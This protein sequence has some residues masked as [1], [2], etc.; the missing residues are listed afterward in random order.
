M[1]KPNPNQ[2]QNL[3]HDVSWP[4]APVNA[5]WEVVPGAVGLIAFAI[6]GGARHLW[7]LSAIA[8]AIATWL[9]ALS[10]SHGTRA[11]HKGG[12]NSGEAQ[13]TAQGERKSCPW[14]W[15]TP[16]PRRR[17]SLCL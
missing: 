12:A 6:E 11:H 8:T 14:T 10:C 17:L 13:K 16:A 5:T 7:Q 15:K 4:V 2:N 3:N 9:G 1:M